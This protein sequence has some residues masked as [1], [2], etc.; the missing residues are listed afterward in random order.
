M[1]TKTLDLKKTL[2]T[3][4]QKRLGLVLVFA[5]LFILSLLIG[6]DRN[7]SATN[8]LKFN[9][10]AWKIFFASRLPRT[11][12]VVLT[13]SGLSVAGLIMPVHDDFK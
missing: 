5:M 9:A 8:L 13:A 4:M 11:V 7:V 1:N 12:A 3:P 2:F 10:S 6:V